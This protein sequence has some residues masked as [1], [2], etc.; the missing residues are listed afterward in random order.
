MRG[1]FAKRNSSTSAAGIIEG[2]AEG[3]RMIGESMP[4]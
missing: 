2:L 4:A 1:E 3:T